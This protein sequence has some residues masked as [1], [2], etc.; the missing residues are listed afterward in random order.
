RDILMQFGRNVCEDTS[1]LKELLQ[2]RL[3]T[4]PG[5]HGPKIKILVLAAREGVA[6]GLV[7]SLR[8]LPPPMARSRASSR[9]QSNLALTADA[10]Q[11]AI[12]TWGAALGVWGEFANSIPPTTVASN[13]QKPPTRPVAALQETSRPT[14]TGPFA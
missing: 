6:P 8:N 12:E 11:W 10:A 5:K 4:H 7:G 1:R 14:T 2:D 13:S 9:L 3:E